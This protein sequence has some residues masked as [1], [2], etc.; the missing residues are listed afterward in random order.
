[1]GI[2]LILSVSTGFQL[3]IDK[4]EEDALSSYPLT[5]TAETADA[6][7]AILSMVT[8]NSEADGTEYIKEKQYI[9]T[10]FSSIET[11]DLTSLKRYFEA[12]RSTVEQ[13]SS[14]VTYSYS[15]VPNIYTIDAAYNISKINPNN[16]MN[17]MTSNHQP[18]DFS[19]IFN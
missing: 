1:M 13:N 5:I 3:Y 14:L 12:N 2:A 8:D 19:S 10:M 17:M 18:D 9:T 7:G 15:V 16:M 4:V 6:T 11:N